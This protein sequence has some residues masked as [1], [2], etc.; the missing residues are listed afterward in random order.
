MFR[1]E[2]SKKMGRKELFLIEIGRI[3]VDQFLK[4]LMREIHEKLIDLIDQNKKMRD[5]LG[6]KKEKIS[7]FENKM[8]EID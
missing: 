1:E 8:M 3:S 2:I 4:T 7:L 6:E 5:F